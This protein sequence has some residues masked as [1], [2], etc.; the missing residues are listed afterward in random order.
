MMKKAVL[1][2]VLA[3]AAASSVAQAD[4]FNWAGWYVGGEVGQSKFVGNWTNTQAFNPTGTPYTGLA[5]PNDKMKSTGTTEAL[6]VGYNWLVAPKWVAG[7]EFKA[8]FANQSAQV[9]DIPGL[10]PTPGPSSSTATVKAGNGFTLKARGGYL[11][12][13]ETM[14]YATAG[15][16]YQKVTVGATCPADTFICNPALGTVGTSTSHNFMGW[17]IGLGAEQA[18]TNHWIGRLDY[19]Y[20][21]FK[22]F[23][24]VA[25]QWVSGAAFGSNAS[26]KPTSQTI[27]AGL[28]YKF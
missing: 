7:A 18:F 5:A 10:D 2:V 25:L 19:S 1:A 17:T 13:P 6:D 8:T 28:S 4:D 12:T 14:L 23:N 22:S 11:V 3:T 9:N 16:A 24:F 26:V 15:V 21:S 20:T 27:S